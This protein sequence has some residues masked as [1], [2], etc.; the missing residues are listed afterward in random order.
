MRAFAFC[1]LSLV[2]FLISSCSFEPENNNKTGE[3]L[4]I[5]E[6]SEEQ[7]KFSK[8]D[9]KI[10]IRETLVEVLRMPYFPEI[11]IDTKKVHSYSKFSK[12][13]AFGMICVELDYM[14]IY[15][16]MCNDN[17]QYMVAA[18]II[19]DTLKISYPFQI[20]LENFNFSNAI[21][22]NNQ[23]SNSPFKNGKLDV[24][25]LLYVG[26]FI[27]NLNLLLKSYSYKPSEEVKELL[28][29]QKQ[30][31]TELIV[32][33]KYFAE[34]KGFK[35]LINKLS[36]LNNA[37]VNLSN[38]SLDGQEFCVLESTFSNFRKNILTSSL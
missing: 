23:L 20:A 26:V 36:D 27:E 21:V 16:K 11:L 37:F 14:N 7:K 15:G 24:L 3:F 10:F 33:L 31:I 35:V 2:I 19:S 34:I 12:C 9:S 13:I 17:L 25:A 22:L 8:L 28:I 38:Q 5:N 4:R 29:Y 6:I 30:T 32:L 1:Q 18:K